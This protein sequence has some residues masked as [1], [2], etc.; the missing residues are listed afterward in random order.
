M[1]ICLLSLYAITMTGAWDWRTVAPVEPARAGYA[2]GV[3]NGRFIL[4]GGSF[5]KDGEKRRVT[6][7]DF[8]EPAANAWTKGPSAPIALSDT[9]STVIGDEFFMLGGTEGATARRQVYSLSHSK[10]RERPE[11]ILPEGRM[12]AVA[13]NDGQRIFLMAGLS[14][15]GD[16]TSATKTVWSLDPTHPATGWQRLSDCPG[17]RRFI[18]TSAISG[19]QLYVFGGGKGTG[20]NSAENLDDIWALDLQSLRWR[21]MGSLPEPRRAMWAAP[22]D[23]KILLFGGYTTQFSNE[24]LAFDPATESTHRVGVLPGPIA[25]AKFFQ[26]GRTWITAGGEVGPK[27][28]GSETWAG[29]FS[30]DPKH[31]R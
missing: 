22:A 31:G 3:L 20:P 12:N 11:L 15:P 24:I 7:V 19:N 10:W 25:D 28:R 14:K 26:I 17:N 1:R 2:A 4:V 27:I 30:G 9:A 16:F 18:V 21:K 13:V 5:W 29:E 8:Y 6:D 23:G